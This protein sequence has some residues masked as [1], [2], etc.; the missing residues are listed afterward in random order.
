MKGLILLL[1]LGLVAGSTINKGVNRTIDASEAIVK[2]FTEIEITNIVFE[3]YQLL[4]T[5]ENAA[6]LSFLSVVQKLPK[7]KR[8]DLTISSGVKR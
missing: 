1:L 2:T 7:K 3:E 8:I 6:R 4:F 5:L